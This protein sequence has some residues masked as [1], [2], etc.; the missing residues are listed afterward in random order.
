VFSFKSEVTEDAIP[1]E[2]IPSIEKGLKTAMTTGAIAGYPLTGVDTVLLGG[3]Y[4]NVDSTEMAYEVAASMALRDGVRKAKPVVLEP[5]MEVE[6]I[7]HDDYM[8]SVVGDLNLRRGKIHGMVPKNNVQAIRAMIPLAEMFGYA[9]ALRNMTQ[10]RGVYTMQFSKY[11]PLPE[12]V[13]KK[14]FANIM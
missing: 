10:G 5:I 7:C 12:E 13:S 2:F 14:M 4:H 9:T 6:V 3:S 8:G 11:S 1:R